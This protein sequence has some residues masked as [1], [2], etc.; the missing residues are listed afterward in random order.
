MAQNEFFL[1]KSEIILDPGSD[2]FTAATD[3]STLL[4]SS[5]AYISDILMREHPSVGYPSLYRKVL[6]KTRENDDDPC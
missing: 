1:C 2:H 6:F 3:S 5:C 4:G